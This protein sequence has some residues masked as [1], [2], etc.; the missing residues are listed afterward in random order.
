[1]SGWRRRGQALSVR[2]LSKVAQEIPA[3]GDISQGSSRVACGNPTLGGA[4]FCH[5]DNLGLELNRV[6]LL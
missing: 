1:V 6:V 4:I 2:D 5:S 3:G